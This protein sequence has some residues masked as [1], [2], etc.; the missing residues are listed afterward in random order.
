MY[1]KTHNETNVN[2]DGTSL[3]G[4]VSVS[5]HELLSKFG[6]PTG[7]DGYKSDAEWELLFDDGKVATI[8]NWK[9]GKNYNGPDGLDVRYITNW[10]IGGRDKEV[11]SRVKTILGE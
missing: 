1:F 5:Y 11:V 10:H 7:S 3:Q 4:Y 9:D 8:Y 6:E 2:A